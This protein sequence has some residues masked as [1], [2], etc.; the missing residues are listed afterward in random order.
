MIWE[1]L[2]EK[3]PLVPTTQVAF[4][5]AKGGEIWYTMRERAVYEILDGVHQPDRRTLDGGVMKKMTIPT[6]IL[7]HERRDT[8]GDTHTS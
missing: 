4:C 3:E 2:K 5:I 6:E 7:N 8:D 1:G